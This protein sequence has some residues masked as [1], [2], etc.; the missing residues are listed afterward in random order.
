MKAILLAAGQ[1][2]RLRPLTN[3]RPKCMVPYRGRPL[4]DYV[5]RALR[6]NGVSDIVAVRGYAPGAIDC[7]GLRFY[8]NP[9]YHETNMV[10]TLF[11]AE[12]ELDGDVIVSYTDIAYSPAV[13]RRLLD[14]SGDIAVVIDRDWQRLWRERMSDPLADAESLRLDAAGNIVELG[15]KPGSYADIEGQYIG[16]FKVSAAAWPRLRAF[17]AGLDRSQRYDGKDFDNMY[18][19]SF[20]QAVID[21]LMPVQAVPIHGGWLE[22][23]VPSDLEVSVDLDQDSGKHRS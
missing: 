14:A 9:R 18:M 21:R 20:I 5:V 7:P 13:V 11:C 12:R 22:I 2:A 23:D 8:D 4:L 3:D 17:Y 6:A 10:H 15:K 16:L 1:G 19:T